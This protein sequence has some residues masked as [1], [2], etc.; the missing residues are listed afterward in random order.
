MDASN[1]TSYRIKGLINDFYTYCL[2]YLYKQIS[3]TQCYREEVLF[4]STAEGMGVDPI[5]LVLETSAFAAMLPL[6]K[7]LNSTYGVFAS[8]Y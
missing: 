4:F 7:L 8:S 6:N 2:Y 5:Y 1:P 3:I